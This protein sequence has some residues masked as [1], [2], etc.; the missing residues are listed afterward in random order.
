MEHPMLGFLNE[1]ERFIPVQVP[2]LVERIL[3]DKRLSAEEQ[4]QMA[5]LAQMHQARIHFEFLDLGE[6]VKALYDP[7]NPD[8]DTLPLQP[9]DRSGEQR[10]AGESLTGPP[11]S[12]EVAGSGGLP[13]LLGPQPDQGAAAGGGTPSLLGQIPVQE[14]A[15]SAAL[16]SMAGQP[17]P[18][19]D[20]QFERLREGIEFILNKS[21]YTKLTPEQLAACMESKSRWGLAVKID[22]RQY[23][24]IDVYYRGVRQERRTE[25]T[26]R[27]WWRPIEMPVWVFSRVAVLVRQTG[28]PHGDRVLLK[29]FKEIVI[30]DLKMTWPNLRILM[31]PLDRVML[32]ASAL[33]GIFA[34]LWK[35]LVAVTLSPYVVATVVFGC[36]SAMVRAVWNFLSC[37]DKYVKTLTHNLYYQNLAN[38]LGAL[39]RLVETAEAE[40][41]KETLLAYYLL[42]VERHRDYTAE[43]VD[44]RIE[45][46]LADEFHLAR[47]DFEIEDAL[48][49]LVDKG[50]AVCRTAAC[51]SETAPPDGQREAVFPGKDSL[52]DTPTSRGPGSSAASFSGSGPA[53]ATTD[54]PFE[55]PTSLLAQKSR[56]DAGSGAA[57]QPSGG[58]TKKIWKVYDLPSALSRLDQWWDARFAYHV[59]STDQAPD[60]LAEAD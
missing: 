43:E 33:G 48:G 22:P 58:Q 54:H 19:R 38:N 24:E 32:V 4:E 27:T 29:L 41:V 12:Q 11:P 13:S 15:G 50:L 16:P 46:W 56:V 39:A 31:R 26:W 49:K 10:L 9:A 25:C 45:Q 34:P 60:R 20:N 42:Y 17:R 47:V 52:A 44:R 36:L 7:F 53:S 23:R 18:D 37:K 14:V 51:R 57:D 59:P 40:E 3:A 35:L 1:R 5:A 8:R 21:N 6:R 55:G 28:P 30:D 2:T